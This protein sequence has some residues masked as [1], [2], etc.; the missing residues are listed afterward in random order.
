MDT[1]RAPGPEAYVA[2]RLDHV[3]IVAGVC[4]EIG[5][6]EWLDGQDE[7][8][9]ERVGVGTATVAM[10]LNGLGFSN[11]RLYLVPQFFAT[12]AVERWL[13]PGITA[14]DL[15]DD[16]LGR[17]VDWLYAHDP[18]T[19][20]AGMALRARRAF[21]ITA[22]QVHV[23]TTSFSVTGEY[24]PDLD[25]HTLA[26]T[27]G[28]SRDHRADLKQWML[29]LAT[30]R[31]GD[32]PLFCQALDGNASD[33]VTLVAAVEALAE[34]LRAAADS[35]GEAPLFVADSGLYSA[36]NVARLSAAGVRWISRVPE[37][38][39][40]ARRASGRRRRLAAGGR[41]LLGVGAARSR[42]GALG[43]GTHASRGGARPSDAA[44]AGEHDVRAVATGVVA[45][46]KSPLCK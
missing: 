25:A 24:A 37:T 10:I 17:A 20:F 16:C 46:R 34:Q 42:R 23:D 15:N 9:H 31:H 13:G 36:D 40:E 14:E 19:L 32:V 30:T 41:A 4:R 11:R 35:E 8:S 33:K 44:A 6:A 38:S 12:K 2:E 1:G 5:L 21:G 27:Y 45:F 43:G 28:Y 26:V 7:Q 29:A 22:R 39:M 3:G 18:T